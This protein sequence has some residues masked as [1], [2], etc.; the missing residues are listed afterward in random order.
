LAVGQF[1]DVA[2]ALGKSAGRRG[3]QSRKL[4]LADD[5]YRR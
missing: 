3:D 1:Q 5:S 4:G 2:V